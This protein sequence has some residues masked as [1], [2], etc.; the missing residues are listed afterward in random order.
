MM[1]LAAPT[2]PHPIRRVEQ[3][4]YLNRVSILGNTIHAREDSSYINTNRGTP[5]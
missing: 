2:P 1:L 3:C 4:Y 5:G